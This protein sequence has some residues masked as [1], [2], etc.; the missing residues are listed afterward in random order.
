MN[1]SLLVDG[2]DL[3]S[4]STYS[5]T[6]SDLTENSIRN[7]NGKASWDVV[8]YNVGKLSLTWE[9]ASADTVSA[10][11]AAI[12][13]KKSFKVTFLNTN[14]KLVETRTFYAGDRANELV[15]YVSALSY[16]STLT[17]P[18]VEV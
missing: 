4:P 17:I 8:R 12:R 16:W 11:C 10:V 13:S 15:R 2:I 18:F 3:P 7:A 9:N 14:T 1:F 6:E 5:F